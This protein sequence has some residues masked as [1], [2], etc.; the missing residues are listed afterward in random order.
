MGVNIGKSKAT[1]DSGAIDDYVTSAR[2]VAPYADYLVVNVSSPNTPGL[3]NLQAVD[4]LRPLLA[5]VREAAQ[6]T[7]GRHVPLLVKIAPDLSD[8]DI[9]EVARLV[10][11]LG[12]DGIVA[13]NTTIS[14]DGLSSSAA[15]IEAA[16]AGGLSGQPLRERSLAVLRLLREHLDDSVA[17]ISVGGIGSAGDVS[18]RLAAGATLVQAYTALVYGGPRWPQRVLRSIDQQERVS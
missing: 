16:G 9:V 2:L 1:P 8:D 4:V 10:S 17:I 14:R 3:R 15:Q 7:A 12:L 5:R 13:T 6:E 18:D 11:E